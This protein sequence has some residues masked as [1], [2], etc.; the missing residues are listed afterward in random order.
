[1][2]RPQEYTLGRNVGKVPGGESSRATAVLS[3]RLTAH[4][5]AAV[6]AIARETGKTLSQIVRE[7]LQQRM[8][9]ATTSGLARSATILP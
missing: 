3:V 1:M 8:R 7:A 6:E 2:S 5:V 4:E 9:A